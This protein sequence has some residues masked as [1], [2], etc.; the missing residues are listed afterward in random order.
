[1]SKL[2]R[3][4]VG[5]GLAILVLLWAANPIFSSDF[6]PVSDN[7]LEV[8]DYNNGSVDLTKDPPVCVR[9]GSYD[10]NFF[11][12]PPDKVF[13]YS[14]GTMAVPGSRNRWYPSQVNCNN[15]EFVLIDG[16][17]WN[18][19]GTEDYIDSDG[20]GLP[21]SQ[22]PFPDIATDNNGHA[23]YLIAVTYDSDGNVIGDTYCY[24]PDCNTGVLQ[25]GSDNGASAD[26]FIPAQQVYALVQDGTTY[27]KTSEESTQAYALNPSDGTPATPAWGSTAESSG[28]STTAA[29]GTGS[30]A[31]TE[32]STEGD[33]DSDYLRKIVD[34]TRSA[35][36]AARATRDQVYDAEQQ[37]TSQLSQIDQDI[38]DQSQSSSDISVTN[39]FTSPDWSSQQEQ[40]ND[41]SDIQE[42]A[43]TTQQNEENS[44]SDYLD[45]FIDNS[46]VKDILG[47]SGVSLDSPVCSLSTT[48]YDQTITLDFC[49]SRVTGWFDT[50]GQVLVAVASFSALLI[51][52]L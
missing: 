24:D 29:P 19:P 52:F 33:T 12:S 5:P 27:L 35:A 32:S 10:S 4:V 41:F 48:L 30:I 36:Q 26:M 45:N 14:N 2:C 31:P 25:L 22:D 42:Q 40:M 6:V 44:L 47:N 34:N 46:P 39:D 1:M 9:L 13:W 38:Q 23:L 21:D 51:I 18:G 17:Y 3:C 7:V 20:D 8:I 28:G 43:N 15:Y 16:Q 50:M 37:L 49:D 11:G